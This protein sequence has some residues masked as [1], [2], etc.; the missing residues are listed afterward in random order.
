[1]AGGDVR[2]RLLPR[3]FLEPHLDLADVLLAAGE[4]RQ[5]WTGGPGRAAE[6]AHEAPPVLVVVYGDGHPAVVPVLVGAAEDAVRRRVPGPVA[7][8]RQDLAAGRVGE[9]R[10]GETD[11]PGLHLRKVDVPSPAGAPAV[12]QGGSEDEGGETR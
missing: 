5:G 12:E 3:P 9:D 4:R 6:S 2:R 10:L 8:A 1:E 11:D 7:H